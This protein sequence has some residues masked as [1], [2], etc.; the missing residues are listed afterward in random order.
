MV[1]HGIPLTWENSK[2]MGSPAPGDEERD[3]R[4]DEERLGWMATHPGAALLQARGGQGGT[5]MV[6]T[7][8]RA[9][10]FAAHNFRVE[11]NSN[12]T[13]WFIFLCFFSQGSVQLMET[14]SS[15][16]F[17]DY[18]VCWNFGWS[19]GA[20]GASFYRISIVV[21]FFRW[22]LWDVPTESARRIRWETCSS[23]CLSPTFSKTRIPCHLVELPSTCSWQVESWNCRTKM[24]LL[25]NYRRCWFVNTSFLFYLPL[26]K[27]QEL[28]LKLLHGDG[29]PWIWAWV[30][31]HMIPS[32]L[33]ELKVHS[34]NTLR[35][36]WLCELLR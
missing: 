35:Q 21:W 23:S 28:G 8:P 12:F 36:K 20:P 25:R 19:L 33:F 4:G 17:F 24:E 32:S 6:G 2:L 10:R 29:H 15:Q 9:F 3:P 5:R 16:T 27:S 26:I 1:C 11:N 18:L 13:F 7:F 30:T 14:K 31:V 22:N 34:L